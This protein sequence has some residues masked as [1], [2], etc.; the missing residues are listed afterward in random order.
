MITPHITPAKIV[1]E[2][3]EGWVKRI[4]LPLTQGQKA[5][6]IAVLGIRQV[7]RGINQPQYISPEDAERLINYVPQPRRMMVRTVD[8]MEEY[9]FMRRYFGSK[10]SAIA[11]LAEAYDL[12]ENNIQNRINRYFEGNAA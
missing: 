1:A 3:P 4:D 9:E 6:R 10:E 2:I 8:L 12:E 5:R 7:R 11:R